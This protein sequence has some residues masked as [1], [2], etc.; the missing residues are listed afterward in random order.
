MRCLSAANSRFPSRGQ[1]AANPL[2]RIVG[3][4]RGPGEGATDRLFVAREPSDL[5]ANA[6]VRSGS[7]VAVTLYTRG[8]AAVQTSRPNGGDCPSRGIGNCPTSSVRRFSFQVGSWSVFRRETDLSE[9]RY[10]AVS[11]GTE[12]S[13]TTNNF[14]ESTR[15][16]PGVIP[17][18]GSVLVV[19]GTATPLVRRDPVSRA[20]FAC[21]G[22]A[23]RRSRSA[24]P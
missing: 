20:A 22:R 2:R 16:R 17:G 8:R 3:G 14:A 4:I 24:R 15:S 1:S 6:G 23:A 7:C 19:D 9:G 10:R 13:R 5:P 12:T 21:R 18:G 11:G